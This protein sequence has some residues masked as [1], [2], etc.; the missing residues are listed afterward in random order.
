[1]KILTVVGYGGCGQIFLFNFTVFSNFHQVHSML[2]MV[3]LHTKLYYQVS[4]IRNRETSKYFMVITQEI[5][6]QLS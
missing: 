1:M 3:T 5:L 6:E 2:M 4:I